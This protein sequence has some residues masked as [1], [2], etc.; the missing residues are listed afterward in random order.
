MYPR[1]EWSRSI[2]PNPSC[3]MIASELA[4]ELTPDV[5]VKIK[6]HRESGELPDHAG[7]L[8]VV[9]DDEAAAGSERTPHLAQRLPL[10]VGW[11]VMQ[12]IRA[13]DR[14]GRPVRNGKCF[15]DAHLKLRGRSRLARILPRQLDHSRCGVDAERLDAA[16][17]KRGRL[18]R[19]LPGAASDIEE[20]VAWRKAAASRSHRGSAVG[21]RNL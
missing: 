9:G 17:Y 11:K 3:M 18:D 19:Q 6:A 10:H 4:G 12:E 13:R 16:T 14:V 7:R 21:V 5:F 8:T 20:P 1:K 2:G 15:A